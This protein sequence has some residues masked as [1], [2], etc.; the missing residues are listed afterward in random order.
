MSWMT[1]NGEIVTTAKTGNSTKITGNQSLDV[2]KNIYDLVGNSLEWTLE[3]NDTVFR[4]R[5]GGNSSYTYA[6][7]NRYSNFPYGAGV[8]NSSR[9]TLYVE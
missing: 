3:A 5:R 8:S 9:P 6:P 4:T 7:S 2:Y 1:K